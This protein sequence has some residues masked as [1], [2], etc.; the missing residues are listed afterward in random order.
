MARFGRQPVTIPAGVTVTVSHDTVTVTG[1]KGTLTRVFSRNVVVDVKENEV[2]VTPRSN[3]KQA[4]ADQGTTKSHIQNM[5]TGVTTGWSK[6]LELSGTGFRAEVRGSELLLTV[7]YS[8]TISVTAP[9]GITF[10]VEK[11]VIT[12]SGTARDVVSQTAANIRAVREPD[13]Y[14]G[15]GIKYK[16]EQL[17]LKPGKQ[18]AKAA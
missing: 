4:L 13:A 18:A 7:G 10:L 2:F 12:V 15:K 5:V 3:F 6:Q 14:Q 9:Q 11:N 1:P 17:K 8:H 16:E